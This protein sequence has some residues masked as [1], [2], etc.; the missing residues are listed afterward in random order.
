L[1]ELADALVLGTNAARRGGSSPSSR[2]N[3]RKTNMCASSMIMDSIGSDLTHR[4][5]S[6]LGG[7]VYVPPSVADIA[8]LQQQITALKAELEALK[9]LIEAAQKYD[10]ATGQEECESEEK[11]AKLRKLCEVVGL[12]LSD[13][14]VIPKSRVMN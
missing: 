10:R 13:I 3:F 11:I 9:P 7:G 8:H 4:Y 12:D 5:G 1:A 6:V 14:L 2:T